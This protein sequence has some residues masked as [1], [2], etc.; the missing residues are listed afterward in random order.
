MSPRQII[1]FRAVVI[2]LL[3]VAQSAALPVAAHA[4]A[5]THGDSL[6]DEAWAQP[7]Y[8][9]SVVRHPQECAGPALPVGKAPVFFVC[10]GSNLQ[11]LGPTQT[12]GT[13][14]GWV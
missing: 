9:I 5:H 12:D 4:T 10:P 1:N 8:G 14:P 2:L 6:P 13:G 7:L 3:C 11:K